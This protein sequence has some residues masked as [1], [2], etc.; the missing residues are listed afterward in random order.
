MSTFSAADPERQSNESRSAALIDSRQSCK[1]SAA[2]SG[3]KRAEE[4]QRNPIKPLRISENSICRS[5]SLRQCNT[6]NSIFITNETNLHGYFLLRHPDNN[7]HPQSTSPA[8]QSRLFQYWRKLFN[9]FELSVR[10][11]RFQDASAALRREI[12][13]RSQTL[14]Q[15][16]RARGGGGSE[17][18]NCYSRKSEHE[19]L[20]LRR[21]D[22]L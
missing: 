4:K 10:F 7:H 12:C 6:A 2:R 3:K 20:F 17:F 5:I 18:N 22:K 1:F 19:F 21:R 16:G 11:F 14:Q 15:K 13:F 9:S 8:R